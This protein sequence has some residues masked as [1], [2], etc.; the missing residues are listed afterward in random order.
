MAITKQDI[1][2]LRQADRLAVSSKHGEGKIRCIKEVRNHGPYE[3][4]EREYEIQTD[5]HVVA[6]DPFSGECSWGKDVTDS[7]VCFAYSHSNHPEYSPWPAITALL[8][9]GDEL[10]LKWVADGSNTYFHRASAKAD[11]Y[12]HYDSVS[13]V[14]RRNGQVKYTVPICDSHCEDNSAR[15][16][17][18]Y[19]HALATA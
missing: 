1:K 13:L 11:S 8:R 3:D 12:V 18:D 19:S 9:E 2:A 5:V 6:Y 7:A 10:R 15:M 4:R 14:I 16:I 17:R